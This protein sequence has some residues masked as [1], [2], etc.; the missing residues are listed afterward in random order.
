MIDIGSYDVI[1]KVTFGK[2]TGYLKAGKDFNN[3]I[4]RQQQFFE[5]INVVRI[6]F[7]ST[8]NYFEVLNLLAGFSNAAFGPLLRQ[9]PD[10]ETLSTQDL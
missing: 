9:K 5:Y 3:L 8:Q 6:P 1:G 10:L 4:K 7:E 2:P